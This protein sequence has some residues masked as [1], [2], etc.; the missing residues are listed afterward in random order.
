MGYTQGRR[1]EAALNAAGKKPNIPYDQLEPRLRELRVTHGLSMKEL[2]QRLGYSVDHIKKLLHRFRITIRNNNPKKVVDDAH[3]LKRPLEPEGAGRTG[4][5]PAA[6][7][8]TPGNSPQ[9]GTS[10]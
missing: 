9:S 7:E 5:H 8:A 2:A 1:G 6:P 4:N 3:I 10:K